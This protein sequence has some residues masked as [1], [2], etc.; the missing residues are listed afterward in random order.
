MLNRSSF[1]F[2]LTGRK[3]NDAAVIRAIGDHNYIVFDLPYTAPYQEFRSIKE[4]QYDSRYRPFK[5]E[6]RKKKIAIINLAEWVGHEEEEYLEI[7]VKFLHDYRA[8]FHYDYVFT[9]G[10]AKKDEIKKLYIL[11]A[12]YLYDG[13]IIEDR[14]LTD[15]QVL[16]GYI[17]ANYPV[18]DD[19]AD[20]C[21]DIMT[22]H[23]VKSL[24]QVDMFIQDLVDKTKD[25][26][27]PKLT[28]KMLL[29][30]RR[31]K[32]TVFHT[33]YEDEVHAWEM[34]KLMIKRENGMPEVAV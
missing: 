10:D 8:F 13:K 4:F 11:M 19:V 12:Q 7:F 33:L 27:A 21:A 22:G 3:D 34:K 31:I 2:Y 9:V 1:T 29:S 25:A 17:K 5:D 23:C 26:R 32:E 20:K 28:E 30:S 18:D 16:S 14:T 6:A 15:A 24:P